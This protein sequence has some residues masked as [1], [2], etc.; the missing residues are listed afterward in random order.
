MNN[1]LLFIVIAI[2][3]VAV[4]ALFFLKKLQNKQ[5]RLPR[6]PSIDKQP[7]IKMADPRLLSDQDIANTLSAQQASQAAPQ[8][9]LATAETYIQNQDYPSA[10]NE[11]KRLLMTS[12][13]NTTAMLK[14]LQVY[15][16]TGQYTAFNQLHQKIC[17]IADDKTIQEANF[18]K[19]LID[20]EVAEK[21]AKPAPAP[22][23]K[24]IQIDTIEFDAPKTTER[25]PVAPVVAPAVAELSDEV[26]ELDF[27]LDLST[28]KAPQS[29]ATPA[30][31]AAYQADTPTLMPEPEDIL[32]FDEPT[33]TPTAP[34][35]LVAPEVSA[36]D[37]LMF[38]LEALTQ[39]TPA[40][41]TPAQDTSVQNTPLQDTFTQTSAPSFDEPA[42]PVASVETLATTDTAQEFDGLDFDFGLSDDTSKTPADSLTTQT[43]TAETSAPQAPQISQDD[44]LDFDFGL[45]L[46]DTNV[47]AVEPAPTPVAPT[48]ATPTPQDDIKETFDFGE[49]SLASNEVLDTKAPTNNDTTDGIDFDFDFEAPKQEASKDFAFDL[50]GADKDANLDITDSLVN[51]AK[52]PADTTDFNL[53]LDSTTPSAASTTS[54]TEDIAFDVADFGDFDLEAPVQTAKSDTPSQTASPEAWDFEL[55]AEPAFAPVTTDDKAEVANVKTDEFDWDSELSFATDTPA[56][57]NVI[58]TP[59]VAQPQEIPVVIT[60]TPAASLEQSLTTASDDS[61][62]I[63]L[64]LAKQYMEFGEFDSAKRLLQEVAQEGS[65]PQKQEAHT[66]M[67]MLA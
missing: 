8:N 57:S 7:T 45:S 22:V 55:S 65:A 19:S 49:L 10:I 53:S 26:F 47:P 48:L 3:L 66:L 2:I 13:R 63:T 21:Q 31:V 28:D 30:N 4:V 52:Q 37:E 17:E 58:D 25:A 61:I 24:T 35:A 5:G 64:E 20:Q 44:G 40:Q 18:C 60:P 56:D 39:D 15:G 6:P 50:S 27:D 46:D 43:S 54:S 1:T 36:G 32:S 11:L 67:V 29:T 59:P 16:L 34:T 12:P 33:L 14:L 9:E 42:T 51:D 41:N 38:E 62:Q 23:E